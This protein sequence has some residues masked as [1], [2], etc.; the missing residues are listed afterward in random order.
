MQGLIKYAQQDGW[1]RAALDAPTPMNADERM[2]YK[3]RTLPGALLGGAA[4]AAL[5]AYASRDKGKK[6]RAAGIS[7]GLGTGA[8]LGGTVGSVLGSKK[9]LEG[10]TERQEPLSDSREDL[11]K[12]KRWSGTP[13]AHINNLKL[14][15]GE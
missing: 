9:V 4:G 5:G 3:K 13:G 2:S 15:I 10:R 8:V 14:P 1:M 12:A 6:G 7:A 11:I